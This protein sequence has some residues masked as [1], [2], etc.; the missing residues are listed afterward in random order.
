MADNPFEEGW[1]KPEPPEGGL[2]PWEVQL[3]N[4]NHGALTETLG[5]DITP[6][7]LHYLLTHFDVPLLPREGF[8]LAFEGAF[9]APFSLSLEEIEALPQVTLPVTMECAGNG[10]A[11]LDP[12]PVSM[13]WGECAVGTYEWTGTPLAPLV[14]RARPRAEAVELVFRGADRGFD[15]GEEHAFARSLSLEDL[16]RLDVLL[17]TRHNGLP[18][19]PQHGAPLRLLVPG[20]YGMASVKW[21]TRIEAVTRPFEGYQQVR[22]YRY[23]SHAEDPGRPVREIRV[24]SLMV[25][26]GVPDWLSRRRLVEA[27]PVEIVG[28]AWSGSGRAITRVELGVDDIWIEAELGPR[29]GRYA[30]TPWRARWQARP[31]WHALR[32]RATDEEGNTQPLEPVPDHGGFGNNMAQAVEVFVR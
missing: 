21:L 26:P 1:R 25:P 32:C 15:G 7:G 12:R 23:R 10:R 19:L 24:K 5:L 9:E 27:G 30:W 16:G 31:G 22:T 8:R 14:A 11:R 28:K 17:V 18:L 6:L 2:H 20:W 4:R 3:A 13:P 29:A